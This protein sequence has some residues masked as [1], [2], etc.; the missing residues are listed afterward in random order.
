MLNPNGLTAL[1]TTTDIV[2]IERRFR[3]IRDTCLGVGLTFSQCHEGVAV[4]V[5]ELAFTSCSNCQR[6][7]SL[8][9]GD[10]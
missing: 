10:A 6:L 4:L 1:V 5:R 9:R 8:I 7:S 3:H 2:L